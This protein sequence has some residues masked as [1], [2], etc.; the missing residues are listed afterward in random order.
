MNWRPYCLH[1]RPRSWAIVFAHYVCG[2][3]LLVP[4]A[5]AGTSGQALVGVLIGGLLWAIC[6]NGATLA[7]NSA[8][9][10]DEGDIGYLDNPPPVPPHLA[11]FAL[12]LLAGGC[13]GAW[14]LTP[15]AHFWLL[16]VGAFLSVI[17]SVPP[18]RLKAIAGADAAINMLGYGGM[19]FAAGG[20][21]TD[22]LPHLPPSYGQRLALAASGFA[23][24]F[25]A[26]Y[27]MTQIYQIPED[28]ARGD[29][30]LALVLGP[31]RSLRL[32]AV[33]ECIAFACFAAGILWDDTPSSVWWRGLILLAVPFAGWLA[34]T[35]AWYRRIET[36]PAKKGMYRAL[37]LWA[38]T[39]VT[40]VLAWWWGVS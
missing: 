8:F 28:A 18:V 19:T 23:F 29:R 26:F 36:Y 27:P 11:L 17:Y 31:R 9:D 33:L 15:R 25:G 35:A 38:L 12:A 4:R 37:W 34:F 22:L 1:L 30:T 3:M 20:F 5:P 16:V 39:D 21:V 14:V 32:A 6:L 24:L 40:V 13:A 10:R 2:A 7:L